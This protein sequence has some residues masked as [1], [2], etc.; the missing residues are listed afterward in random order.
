MRRWWWLTALVPAAFVTRALEARGALLYP[1]GYQYLLMAKGIAAHGRPIV[2]LG[3]GGDT[4]LP[5][6][7]ASVKPLFPALVALLHIV[8]LS[9]RAAGEVVT[10]AASGTCCVLVGLLAKRLTGSAVAA[11]AAGGLCV[12]SPA[13]GHWIA[14]SGPDPL[15]QALALGA[16]LALFDRRPVVAGALAGLCVATRPEYAVLVV[17]LFVVSVSFAAAACASVAVVLAAVRP[18]LA[19]NTASSAIAGGMPEGITGLLRTDWPLLLLGLLGLACAPRRHALAL[20]GA[21][22]LLAATYLLKDPGSVRYFAGV[23]PFACVAAA[24]ALARS[25]GPVLAVVVATVALAIPHADAPPAD[26]FVTVAARLAGSSPMY[27]S[28]PDAYG[29]MV[30][31]P[32]RF[33]RPGIRGLILLDGPQRTYEPKIAACGRVVRSIVPAAGFVR[34]DGTLDERPITLVRGTAFIAP[35]EPATVDDGERCP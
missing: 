17:P 34:P 3:A 32:V 26:P 4:W 13:L 18:P 5:S 19:F 1:D 2:T 27:T 28:A 7:D 24:Y 21:A 30:S 6:A 15:A 35:D 23:V 22:A 16:A 33:L 11:L 14:F 31:R 9:L 29:L 25:T 20:G 8:G 12:A 10:V